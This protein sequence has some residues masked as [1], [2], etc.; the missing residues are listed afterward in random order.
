MQSMT[1]KCWSNFS[2]WEIRKG[3]LGII[4]LIIRSS[5]TTFSLR[6]RRDALPI[7]LHVKP[8]S[9]LLFTYFQFERYPNAN[10]IKTSL[11]TPPPYP[12]ILLTIL[13]AFFCPCRDSILFSFFNSGTS[14]YG[15]FLIFS[16]LGFMA[17]NQGVK[18]EDVAKSGKKS[19]SVSDR[20]SDSSYGCHARR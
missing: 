20:Q 17:K 15:G 1:A 2:R 5:W 4:V 13:S 3:L 12:C 14:F 18:V 6:K 11:I 10:S 19:T 9:Y 8:C 16:V 7:Y